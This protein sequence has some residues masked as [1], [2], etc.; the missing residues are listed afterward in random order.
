[1]LQSISTAP[2]LSLYPVYQV[3]I[4]HFVVISCVLALQDKPHAFNYWIKGDVCYLLMLNDRESNGRHCGI[5]CDVTV[6][7]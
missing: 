3:L 4:L 5:Y 7:Q 1:M 6:L 2:Y